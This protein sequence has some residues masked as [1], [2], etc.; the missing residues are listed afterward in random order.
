[1]FAKR[2]LCGLLFV[3]FSQYATANLL[4]SPTRVSFDERQRSAKVTVINSSEEY[5]T[6]RVVWSE[7]LALPGGGYQTLSEPVT[8]SL[9]P[10]A[11]LSPKQIRLA[12]GERQT[13]KIAIRKPKDLAK[14]EYRS[15]LLF[16]ALPNED[17]AAK[18]GLKVNM[19]LS[20][21]IPVVYREQGELPKVAFQTAEIVEDSLN[22]KP[23]IAVKLTEQQGFSSYGRLSA[24]ITN[25]AGKQEKIAE[26]G[27]LSLYPEVEQATVLLD[28]FSGKQLPKQGNIELKYQ[29]ADEYEGVDFGSYLLP[30]R[31]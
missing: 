9:S 22:K 31:H 12:P 30:I 4:I 29:G 2:L 7:K 8:T 11:R 15:H 14:G 20:F 19:I 16:Q 27:N 3:F 10:M 6:Y 23:K 24:Y 25:S 13:I 17:K 18:A 26:I 28:L 21:S 5:R 1:M